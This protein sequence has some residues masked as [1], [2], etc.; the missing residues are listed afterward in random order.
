MV[1]QL[2][3]I[4]EEGVPLTRRVFFAF[5][6]SLPSKAL[7]RIHVQRAIDHVR[8][9]EFRVRLIRA[10]RSSRSHAAQV[11]SSEYRQWLSY[12]GLPLPRALDDY[13][14]QQ[15]G[16]RV[17][18][19]SRGRGGG[20]QGPRPVLAG[21]IQRSLGKCVLSPLPETVSLPHSVPSQ[22]RRGNRWGRV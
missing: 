11:T 15:S 10:G 2:A 7:M 13:R 22:I 8:D 4:V 12:H 1:Q 14:L 18:R 5:V 16:G 19:P 6:M 20:K 17:G 9:K 21:L 3:R